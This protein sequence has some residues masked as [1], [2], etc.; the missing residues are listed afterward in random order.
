MKQLGLDLGDDSLKETPKRIARMYVDEIFSGLDENNFPRIMTI[1]NK[2]NYDQMLI[3]ANIGI[4]SVCEHHFVPIIGKAHIAY[5]P[6]K[7]IIGLSKLNRVA[8]Y[9]SRRPQV[10]ERLT[11]NIKDKICEVVETDNVAVTIDA[12]HYCV[13]MRGAKDINALTRTSTLGGMFKSETTTRLEYF[14]SI[15]KMDDFNG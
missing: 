2:F 5:I 8:D 3:E 12:I 7:K 11:A 4:Y 14:N 13:I 15:P 6:N 9:F 10:Q 1:E